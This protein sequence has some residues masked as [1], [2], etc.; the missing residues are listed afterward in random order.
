MKRHILLDT[1]ERSQWT[2]PRWFRVTNR[3]IA[4]QS[5]FRFR[6]EDNKIFYEVRQCS[7][8]PFYLLNN[9]K[10]EVICNLLFQSSI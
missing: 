1:V 3:F 6:T 7:M 2:I 5:G 4:Y 8:H 9:I 10:I